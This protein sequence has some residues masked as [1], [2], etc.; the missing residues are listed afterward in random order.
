[1]T[2]VHCVLTR[3]PQSRAREDRHPVISVG[4][5]VQQLGVRCE[6]DRARERESAL[7]L[8]ATVVADADFPQSDVPPRV[9]PRGAIV[10]AQSK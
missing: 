2:S 9:P 6:S 1:M 5:Q 10:R 4:S 3:P 8:R 7:R